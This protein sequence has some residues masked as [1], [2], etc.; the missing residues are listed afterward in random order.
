MCGHVSA[1]MAHNDAA[2]V[3]C[4]SLAPVQA[5][6]TTYLLSFQLQGGGR[7]REIE[8]NS[9]SSHTSNFSFDSPRVN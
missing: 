7:S 3:L 8:Q 2:C 1:L 5:V 4:F 6:F 9:V